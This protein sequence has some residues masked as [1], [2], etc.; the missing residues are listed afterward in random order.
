GKFL[1]SEEVRN[2]TAEMFF[3]LGRKPDIVQIPAHRYGVFL[4]R[5]FVNPIALILFRNQV[6]FQQIPHHALAF[7]A[8]GSVRAASRSASVCCAT[9]FFSMAACSS[10]PAA[11]PVCTAFSASARARS[12]HLKNFIIIGCFS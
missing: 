8:V 7:K 1:A 9:R 11:S 2:G 3:F 6:G 4:G 12:R 5:A 10:T